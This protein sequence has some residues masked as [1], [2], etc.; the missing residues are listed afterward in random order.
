MM[1]VAVDAFFFLLSSSSL[2]PFLYLYFLKRWM[3][4][5]RCLY[6]DEKRE[7]EGMCGLKDIPRLYKARKRLAG[8]IKRRQANFSCAQAVRNDMI[9]A[10]KK[11]G[12]EKKLRASTWLIAAD[13]SAEMAH[14]FRDGAR[15]F[16][17]MSSS[18][19]C[20]AD[21]VGSFLLRQRQSTCNI[22][23][24][25]LTT[26]KEEE[27]EQKS[28]LTMAGT[29]LGFDWRRDIIK[30]HPRWSFFSF[31]LPSFFWLP[32]QQRERNVNATLGNAF[33]IGWSRARPVRARASP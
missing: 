24:P 17:F 26:G 30:R 33:G 10:H 31:F 11:E 21:E 6:S 3:A 28:L 14:K 27:S 18:Q 2:L 9:M 22:T 12:E 25:H 15:S 1:L 16:I 29:V 4:N 5:L 23:R 13:R 19:S 32:R 20:I 8:R 7:R